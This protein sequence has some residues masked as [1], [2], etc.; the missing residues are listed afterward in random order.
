MNR[1][2]IVLLVI[3]SSILI[4]GTVVMS[5]SQQGRSRVLFNFNR[6]FDISSVITSDSKVTLSKNRFLRIET[7][8]KNQ[9]PGVTL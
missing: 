5:A 4:N 1:N 9:W 7:G 6:N 8:H 2:G 3:V